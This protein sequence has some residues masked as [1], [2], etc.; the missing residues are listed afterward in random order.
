MFG[1]LILLVSFAVSISYGFSRHYFEE[2]ERA[3]LDT[4]SVGPDCEFL[5]VSD[6]CCL[7]QSLNICRYTNDVGNIL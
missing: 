4:F 5:P 1:I 7:K 6:F 3:R 2:R